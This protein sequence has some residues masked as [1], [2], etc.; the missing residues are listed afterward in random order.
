MRKK[1][2]SLGLVLIFTCTLTLP[3]VAIND[4]AEPYYIGLSRVTVSLDIQPTTLGAD[5]AN[6]Y[7]LVRLYTG[8]SA[9]VT[10][11]LQRSSDEVDWSTVK[12]WSDS[13]E[14][15]IKIDKEYYVVNG[16]SYRLAVLVYVY[17]ESG[18][19]AEI[20]TKYSPIQ[21]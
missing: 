10:L 12:S 14:E 20:I 5:L 2:L 8:Y 15:E 13:G 1:I 17:Y 21:P 9:D 6:C 3:A 4:G 19:L 11:S 16:Y 7:T 18:S